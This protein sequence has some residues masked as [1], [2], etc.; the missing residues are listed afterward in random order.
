MGLQLANFL[1]RRIPVA[2]LS[3][4]GFLGFIV[5]L[6]LISFVEQEAQFL[7]GYGAFAWLNSVSIGSFDGAGVLAAVFVA[8][9]GFFYALVAVAAQTVLNGMVPLHLQG[10]VLATQGAMAA[11]ASSLPVLLAGAL[12]DLAG[13]TFVMALLACAISIVAFTILRGPQRVGVRPAVV[14]R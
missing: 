7:G 12:T 3:R 8:P 4:T 10:R 2:L 11:I 6:F 9:L 1:A 13:V 14:G 5:F